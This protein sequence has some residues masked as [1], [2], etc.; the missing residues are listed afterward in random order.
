MS[1]HQPGKH[2]PGSHQIL[3]SSDPSPEPC[4]I[5]SKKG[6]CSWSVSPQPYLDCPTL[7]TYEW[8]FGYWDPEPVRG[9]ECGQER[10]LLGLSSESACLCDSELSTSPSLVSQHLTSYG[11]EPA[12]LGNCFSIY[13]WREKE[14][15]IISQEQLSVMSHVNQT[16]SI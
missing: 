14:P 7:P 2:L 9:R 13:H 8:A 5:L 1:L 12:N 10:E 11:A 3:Y 6:F 15:G 4:D 16:Q